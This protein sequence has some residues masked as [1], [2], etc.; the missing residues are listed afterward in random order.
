MFKRDSTDKNENSMGCVRETPQIKNIRQQGSV[1]ETTHTQ[2]NNNN[3]YI[4][5]IKPVCDV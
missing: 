2:N 1:R 3:I 4:F 5:L